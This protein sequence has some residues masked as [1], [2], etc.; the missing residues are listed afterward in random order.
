MDK[1]GQWKLSPAFD[2]CHAYRPGSDWVSQH[3][4][5]IRGKRKNINRQDVLDLASEMNVKKA[6][7]IIDQ[8]SSVVQNWQSY[9]ARVLLEPALEQAIGK[10]LINL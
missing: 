7:R 2:V 9:S 5:S 6:D 8:I 3:A 10:T 1:S 4:L